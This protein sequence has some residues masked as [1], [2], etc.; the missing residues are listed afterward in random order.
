LEKLRKNT[1]ILGIADSWAEFEQGTSWMQASCITAVP[2]V[3][4]YMIDEIWIQYHESIQ[5]QIFKVMYVLQGCVKSEKRF[6]T[7]I[8]KS[9]VIKGFSLKAWTFIKRYGILAYAPRGWH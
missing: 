6:Q 3:E 2:T 5:K 7:C 4:Q 8:I 9:V 1:K